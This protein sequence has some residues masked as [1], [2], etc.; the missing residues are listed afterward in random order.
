VLAVIAGKAADPGVLGYEMAQLVK[1]V[2]PYLS[3]PARQEAAAFPGAL[4]R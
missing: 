2:R 1:S 3:T 4:G